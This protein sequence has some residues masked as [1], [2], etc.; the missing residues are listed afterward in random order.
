V[1]SHNQ[2]LDLAWGPSSNETST[3]SVR[4]YISYIRGKIEEDP[5]NPRLI[6][7]V[8]EFGYRYVRPLG[9]TGLAAAA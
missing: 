8:R 5:K 4:L 1:L 6:E 2:L 3:D 9:N 7:T